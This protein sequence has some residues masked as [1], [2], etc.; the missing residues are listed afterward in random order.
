MIFNNIKVT[1]NKSKKEDSKRWK[2][3]HL[4]RVINMII[5]Y[6]FLFEK[7]NF[8]KNIFTIKL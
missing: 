6:M 5:I 1:M 7:L 2:K 4:I 3:N 8:R